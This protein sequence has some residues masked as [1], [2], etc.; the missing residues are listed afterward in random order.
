MAR[1][2]QSLGSAAYGGRE[3][4]QKVVGE[5][6]PRYRGHPL[7]VPL[8][9]ELHLPL[10]LNNRR[11]ISTIA[12]CQCP[13]AF[14]GSDPNHRLRR[15]G[16][17][18]SASLKR[19]NSLNTPGWCFTKGL[20]RGEAINLSTANKRKNRLQGQSEGPG[21][22]EGCFNPRDGAPHQGPL[23]FCLAPDQYDMGQDEGTRLS[24]CALWQM[25]KALSAKDS[26]DMETRDLAL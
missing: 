5:R 14:L 22:H 19:S 1:G 12:T 21:A 8:S 4:R 16:S 11:G 9:P 13:V 24:T 20:G 15:C 26:S 3:A 18:L 10:P 23:G 6:E 7:D 17:D 2:C 25:G